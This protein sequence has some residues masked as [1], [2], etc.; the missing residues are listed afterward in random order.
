[1]PITRIGTSSKF[2]S[3]RRHSSTTFSTAEPMSTG[4]EKRTVI[5][6]SSKSIS[7]TSRA[8]P[9]AVASSGSGT[10]SS[11]CNGSRGAHRYQSP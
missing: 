7:G 4:R 10:T 11:T 6:G 1:M 2:P 3:T 9:P 5:S 8:A